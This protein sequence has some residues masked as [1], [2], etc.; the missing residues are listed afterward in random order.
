MSQ[1]DKETF[2]EY[3]QRRRVLASQISPPLEE[4]EM[5]KIFLKTL[6][7]FYYERMI[8]SAPNDFTEMVNMG[9]RLEEEVREERLSKEEASSSKRYGGSFS[10]KKEGETNSVTVRRQ[11]R[12]HVRKILIQQQQRQQQP[13]Q[14]TNYN[15]NNNN[16]QQNFERKKVSFDPIPM[17]YAELYPFLVLK[18]F[19]Q[20]RNP[21]QIP[22]PLPW[23]FK[24]ELR[25]A[26]HQGAPGHD[27]ENC[28]P[29]KYEV[30]KLVN[31]GMVSFNDRAPNVK[32]NLLPAHGNASVNMVDDCRRNFQVFDV[33]RIRRSL[34]EMHRTLCL[35]SDCEHDHDGCAICSVNPH[36]CMIVKKDIQKLMDENVI[37]IQQSRD[38]DDVNVI[39]PV[40]KTLERV[41]IQFDSS[42]SNNSNR[43]VSSLVIRLA[44][45]VPYTSDKAMP[46][47][48]NTTMIEN[49]QEVPL[50]VADSVVNIANIAKVTSKGHV[51]GPVFPKEVED[52]TT[53]KNA[54]IPIMNPI[55][56]PMCQ[57]GEYNKLKASDDDE[58]LKLIKRSEFNMV[59]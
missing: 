8:T 2:K 58:V 52:A 26:F 6:S 47:Q 9:M 42:S 13:Q 41:V 24:P 29:L 25:C 34:V 55:S 56:T 19:I 15:N 28:Y 30:Q 51:F 17:T 7:S 21:P 32:A 53:S 36:G 45:P 43:L 46:Y 57:S 5:T 37:Q 10:K 27:I 35:I 14:R 50:P 54:E 39:M 59:D 48:Y 22:E 4:K 40:F 3:A 12:P 38:I 1:K 18:N 23:W 11:N 16:N 44:G 33:R 31:S 49:G 20:P